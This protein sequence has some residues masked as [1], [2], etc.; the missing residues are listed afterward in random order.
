PDG[1]VIA[2]ACQ[3]GTVRL[4]DCGSLRE[5]RR[6]ACKD[7]SDVRFSPDGR[8][9]AVFGDR[10]VR[11]WKMDTGEELPPVGARDRT[12]PR[13]DWFAFAPDGAS[14]FLHY[15]NDRVCLH[16]LGTGRE[17]QSFPLDEDV[18]YWERALSPD[19]KVLAI[20]RREDND[21]C[22]WETS[23]GEEIC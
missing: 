1:K 16:S 12:L 18:R 5:G 7:A 10:L 21:V 6:F 4:W 2:A 13:V 15:T 20:G 14:L 23:T 19:G 11:C 9:L 22:L 3:D 17:V 8:L